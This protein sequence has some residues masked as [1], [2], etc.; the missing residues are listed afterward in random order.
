MAHT[1][2]FI[3]ASDPPNL[4]DTL[5]SKL[6]VPLKLITLHILT[7]S[8]YPLHVMAQENHMMTCSRVCFAAVLYVGGCPVAKTEHV[9]VHVF[10]IHSAGPPQDAHCC[11]PTA[12]ENI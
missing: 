6:A 9:C 1:D 2:Q 10:V 12:G 8:N 11:C 4:A 7:R 3:D 5:P